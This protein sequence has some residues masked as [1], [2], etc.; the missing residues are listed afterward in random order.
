MKFC[1]NAQFLKSFGRI[2]FPQN[3]HTQKL[4]EILV[5]YN[6]TQYQHCVKRVRIRSYSGPCF[7][8]FGLNTERYSVS[9][10]IH[11]ECGKIRTRITSNTDT[12][13]AVPTIQNSA[14]HI[15]R[16][17]SASR[18]L[19]NIYYGAFLEK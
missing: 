11:S 15:T 4:G 18:T 1:R 7:P 17:R 8:A 6:F 5:F 9:L 2:A 10:H 13:Y 19:L 14:L 16:Y 3:F 12:F